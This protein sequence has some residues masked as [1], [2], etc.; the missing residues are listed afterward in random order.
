VLVNPDG[1]YRR[2]GE[3]MHLP[4]GCAITPDGKTLICAESRQHRLTAYTI[5]ADGSLSDRRLYAEL[6][7][8]TVPDGICLDAEGAIWVG[9]VTNNVF[10]R[11]LP[12]GRVTDR[13][14]VPGKYA[15]ACLL[16]G[17]DWRTL[18]LCTAKTTRE[19]LAKGIATGWIETV[20]VPVPGAGVP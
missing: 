20:R 6:G 9:A 10:L 11:V 18:F 7:E 12:G 4:N 1:S 16:G 2:V 19:D 15:V 3:E 5:A 17:A 14:P 8:G 13:I